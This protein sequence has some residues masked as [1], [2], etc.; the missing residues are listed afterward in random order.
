MLDPFR[1]FNSWQTIRSLIRA[2]NSPHNIKTVKFQDY[3]DLILR[4]FSRNLFPNY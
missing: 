1:G 3:V 4:Q 2:R